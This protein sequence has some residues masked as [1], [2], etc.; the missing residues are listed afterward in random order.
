[1]DGKYDHFSPN[2]RFAQKSIFKNRFPSWWGKQLL[3]WNLCGKIY[4]TR[5]SGKFFAQI[6]FFWVL[7]RSKSECYAIVPKS[8]KYAK[9]K[10]NVLWPFVEGALTFSQKV[11]WHNHHAT[12]KSL[13]IA[14]KFQSVMKWRKIILLAWNCYR[15]FIS[16][17][18]FG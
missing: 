8:R 18:K 1:M 6:L 2:G 4:Q 14:S 12:N 5:S 7:L 3:S 13:N 10:N 16:V 15:I 17:T 11:V 9:I